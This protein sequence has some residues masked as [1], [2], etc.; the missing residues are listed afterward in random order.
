MYS[1]NGHRLTFTFVRGQVPARTKPAPKQPARVLNAITF[2]FIQ[3]LVP[4]Y[5]VT[6]NWDT[7]QKIKYLIKH[8]QEISRA[9]LPLILY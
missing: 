2:E 4:F 1:P 7:P 3:H 5:F 8:H 9:K 6:E